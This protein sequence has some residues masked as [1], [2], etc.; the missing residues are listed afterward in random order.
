MTN[1]T[2]MSDTPWQNS[3]MGKRNSQ[4]DFCCSGF[5]GMKLADMY[6]I[7]SS[8]QLSKQVLLNCR[9]TLHDNQISCQSQAQ[10]PTDQRFIYQINQMYSLSMFG[11]FECYA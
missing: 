4:H 11:N 9:E 3:K 1:Q 5:L 2:K 7:E 8:Q 10:P 6:N